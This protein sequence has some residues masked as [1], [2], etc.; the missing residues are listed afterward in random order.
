MAEFQNVSDLI[1]VIPERQLNIKSEILEIDGESANNNPWAHLNKFLEYICT[2]NNSYV[3]CCKICLPKERQ[4]R[5]HK[6]TY[7]NIKTHFRKKHQY[8]FK[9][10]EEACDNASKRGM[11]YRMKRQRTQETEQTTSTVMSPP[12]AKIKTPS[13]TMQVSICETTEISDDSVGAS[14]GDIDRALVNLVIYG[15]QLP[16]IVDCPWF[17]NFAQALNPNAIIPSITSLRH[18]ITETVNEKKEQLKR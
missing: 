13:A 16:E 8:L 10:I 6:T 5:A 18:K 9:E 11:R 14:N 2:E 3:F 15:M 12:S 4:L 17:R 7:S 1:E